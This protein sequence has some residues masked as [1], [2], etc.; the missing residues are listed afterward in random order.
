MRYLITYTHA[1]VEPFYTKYY[2][3]ENNFVSGMV[4]FDLTRHIYTTNGRDWI[5][6]PVNHL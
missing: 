1:L 3:Y 6:T 2:D 4:V 5:D